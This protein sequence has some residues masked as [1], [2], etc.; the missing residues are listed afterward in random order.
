MI[1][2]DL[3]KLLNIAFKNAGYECECTVIESNRPELCDYQCDDAF[4]LAKTYRTSPM[5]IANA[6]IA[7][8]DKMTDVGEYFTRFEFVTPGFINLTLSDSF[9][10]KCLVD[11]DSSEN[12]GLKT[13]APKTYFLDY[14]GP[15]IAKPLHVGHLR[16][17]IVG[18]SVKRILTFAGHK[19][20]SDV[21]LGDY[22]LQIGQVIYGLKEKNISID[23]ISL[24]VLEKLYPVHWKTVYGRKF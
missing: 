11:I 14:G 22:G 17:A 21:H 3:Q 19:T 20:I 16:S 24:E 12:F 18:E 7:E 6:V 4:K 8:L 2:Q 1:T 9:I 13:D 10:N 15:N 5:N 23:E